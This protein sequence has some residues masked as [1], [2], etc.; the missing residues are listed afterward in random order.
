MCSAS[1]VDKKMLQDSWRSQHTAGGPNTQLAVPADYTSHRMARNNFETPYVCTFQYEGFCSLVA[2][3]HVQSHE[4]STAYLRWHWYTYS[5]KPKSA[6]LL[7]VG[8]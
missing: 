6:A 7:I 3:Q 4:L 5:I 1:M 2:N 8:S